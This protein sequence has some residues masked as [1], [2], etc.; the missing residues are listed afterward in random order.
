MSSSAFSTLHGRSNSSPNSL[1]FNCAI[2]SPPVKR[3]ETVICS[4]KNSFLIQYTCTFICG[5]FFST[6]LASFSMV[7]KASFAVAMDTVFSLS[8]PESS[9]KRSF[10]SSSEKA[11]HSHTIFKLSIPFIVSLIWEFLPGKDKP[12]VTGMNK[13]CS[14]ISTKIILPFMNLC[15]KLFLHL[16]FQ[17]VLMEQVPLCTL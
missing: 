11:H 12:L 9:S 2:I 7:G 15:L 6:S 8:S 10:T 17:K 14:I 13:G 5:N 1:S 4:P 16:L 3:P